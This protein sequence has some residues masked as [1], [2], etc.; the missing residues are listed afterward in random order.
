MRKARPDAE[1]EVIPHVG[2]W[3]CYEA[4]DHMNAQLLRIISRV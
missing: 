1:I 4:A 2:H 3:A